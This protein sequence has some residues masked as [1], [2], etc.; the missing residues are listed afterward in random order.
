MLVGVHAQIGIKF[1][2]ED[3]NDKEKEEKE[4]GEVAD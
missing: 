4:R 3:A 1:D 2:H